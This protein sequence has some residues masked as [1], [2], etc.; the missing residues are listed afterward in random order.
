MK[1]PP[2]RMP[3]HGSEAFADGTGRL[4]TAPPGA[5]VENDNDGAVARAY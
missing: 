5:T 3:A 4:E 2:Y 1:P